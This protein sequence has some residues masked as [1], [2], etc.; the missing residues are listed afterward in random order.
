MK[1]ILRQYYN[2][3]TSKET[4]FIIIKG[5]FQWHSKTNNQTRIQ[6]GFVSQIDMKIKY[7]DTGNI[8]IICF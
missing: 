1:K 7:S 5:C 4:V 3:M 2:P 6:T 8:I